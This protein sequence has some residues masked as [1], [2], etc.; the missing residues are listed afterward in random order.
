MEKIWD[1]QRFPLLRSNIWKAATGLQQRLAAFSP[2]L[3]TTTICAGTFFFLLHGH[4]LTRA[5]QLI[6]LLLPGVLVLLLPART[7]LQHRLRLAFVAI[8]VTM[9]LLDGAVRAFILETYQAAPDSTFV[10]SAVANTGWRESG[11]Y[12]RTFT[13]VLAGWIAAVTFCAL[14]ALALSS[15]G[16]R[17]SRPSSLGIILIASLLAISSLTYAFKPWRKLHPAVFW[18]GWSQSV[19]EMRDDWGRQDAARERRQQL[20]SS[21]RPVVANDLPSTVVLVL[22]ESIN[23]DNMSLYGYSRATTPTLDRRKQELGDSMLVFR[24]AWSVEASTLPSLNQLFALDDRNDDGEDPHILALARAAGYRTWWISNHDDMAIDQLH[25]R[26]ADVVEN[27][28]R[29]PGRS[30]GGL[31]EHLLDNVQAA[32]TDGATRK[33]IVVHL[34]GAHPYYRLRYPNGADAFVKKDHVDLQMSAAGRS[35]R[36]GMLRKEYDSALHYHDTIVARLLDSV[37]AG[38][39]QGDEEQRALMYLSDHGQEV[40]HSADFSGH[41]RT[42]PAG[43][44]IPAFIWHNQPWSIVPGVDRRAFRSDWASWVLADL[45]KLE[46]RGRDTRYNVLSADYRWQA[47]KLPVAIT[48]YT[49]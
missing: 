35:W 43:Y 29:S 15:F 48:A 16:N 11:E 44:R 21:L 20:A 17:T 28:N 9:F 14:G 1:A 8:W 18:P 31:D 39:R 45:L 2:A 34:M 24:N 38:S 40:G 32:L 27:V 36:V 4:T 7:K 22:G 12:A 49:E 10:T 5:M 30:G 13:P 23:R 3:A 41:S 46:W 33:F 47:P 25:A 6:P 19:A 26:L 37:R 42:T